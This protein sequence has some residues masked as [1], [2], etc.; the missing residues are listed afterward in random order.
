MHH[1]RNI[2]FTKQFLVYCLRGD[3]KLWG[4]EY[5][6]KINLKDIKIRL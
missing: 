1:K 3:E 2:S 4:L 6:Y 5:I